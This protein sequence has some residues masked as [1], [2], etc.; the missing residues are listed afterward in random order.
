MALY[1]CGLPGLDN[2]LQSWKML[3]WWEAGRRAHR[4]SEVFLQLLESLQLF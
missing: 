4:S 1:Q 2:V 3:S